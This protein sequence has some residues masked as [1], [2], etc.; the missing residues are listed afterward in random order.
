M[1]FHCHL[2]SLLRRGVAVPSTS[3]LAKIISETVGYGAMLFKNRFIAAK[4]QFQKLKKPVVVP[5]SRKKV[6]W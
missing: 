4:R 1:K 5:F 3:C 2:K 6:Y